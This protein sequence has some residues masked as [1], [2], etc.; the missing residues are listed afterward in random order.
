[1]R[2]DTRP[3]SE[4]VSLTSEGL[5]SQAI[6]H[7]ATAALVKT[8]DTPLFLFSYARLLTQ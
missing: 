8:P 2:L 7:A 1:M 3:N 4:T 5:T 6:L